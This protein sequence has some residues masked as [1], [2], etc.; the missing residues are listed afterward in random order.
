MKF[1]NFSR[2]DLILSTVAG[3]ALGFGTLLAL[4]VLS[5]WTTKDKYS[6][7]DK[8]YLNAGAKIEAA[9]I[10]DAGSVGEMQ[11]TSE[12]SYQ[13]RVTLPAGAGSLSEETRYAGEIKS[14]ALLPKEV[15]LVAA[16]K[17]W[18]PAA[19]ESEGTLKIDNWSKEELKGKLFNYNL[20][21]IPSKNVMAPSPAI[22]K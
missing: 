1:S 8:A 4:G 17:N 2:K 3:S 9:V 16:D 15:E 5:P 13:V 10:L 11:P 6:Y 18:K 20:T 19:S 12:K 22:P 14:S 21:A 7:G